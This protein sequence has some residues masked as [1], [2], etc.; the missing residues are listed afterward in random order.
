M[1]I[2]RHDSPY[3]TPLSLP[4]WH[5]VIGIPFLVYQFLRWFNGSVRYRFYAYYRYQDLEESCRKSLGQGMQKTAEETALKSPLEIDTRAFMWTF[6]CLDEDHEL[7]RFFSGLPGFRSSK[8]V[9]DPLPRLT[10]E[11]QSEL[12][13]A[14]DGLLSR[15]FSSDLLPAPVKNRRATICAKAVDLEHIPNTFLI[16]NTI[17]LEYQHSGPVATGVAKILRGWGKKM[18]EDDIFY[19]QSAISKIIATRQSYDDSWYILASNELGIPETSL[20]D[21]GAHGDDLSLLILIHI[22]HK[23]FNHFGKLNWPRDSFALLLAETSKFNTQDTSPELQHEFCAL[24][25]R[26]VNKAQDGDDRLM[27]FQ[28]LGRIRNVYLALHQVTDSA[29]TEFS[30]STNDEDVI[31]WEPSLYP[32]CEVPDHCSDST[33]IHDS[34]STTLLRAIPH[35]H[36]I[37]AFHPSLACPDQP[38]LS[39]YSPLPIDETLTDSLPFDNQIIVP[40]STQVIGWNITEGRH[41]PT[42]PPSPVTTQA[43]HGSTDPSRTTQPSTSSPPLKSSASASPPS[44]VIAVGLTALRRTPSGDINVLSSAHL[45]V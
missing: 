6:D 8:V 23:Q 34:V 45:P 25:N 44:D 37:P 38:S 35:D 16:L 20:R 15:T 19:A 7:E 30:A 9:D 1:P 17:L 39:T 11:E 36:D 41:S 12:Y 4:V 10:T 32:I 5:I 2:F 14:L 21:Y 42:T 24:W 27:A 33:H 18:N 31:L 40:V 29:P 43:T 13:G 3:Y 28:I 26:I 22:I